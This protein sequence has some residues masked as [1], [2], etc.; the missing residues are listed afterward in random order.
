MRCNEGSFLLFFDFIMGCNERNEYE[1]G[2]TKSN[3]SYHYTIKGF[4]FFLD[5]IMR[6]FLCGFFGNDGKICLDRSFMLLL[7]TRTSS[8]LLAQTLL[9]VHLPLGVA[10]GWCHH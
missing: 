7:A 5:F 10:E 1:R 3:L 4:L 8:P 9:A 2:E 6:F